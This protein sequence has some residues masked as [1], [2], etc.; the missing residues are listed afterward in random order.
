MKKIIMPR[1]KREIENTSLYADGFLLGIEKL[2]INTPYNFEEQELF[3][4]LEEIKDKEVF[5]ALT[6]NMHNDDLKYLEEIM[7]KLE[8]YDVKITYYDIAV[9]NIKERLKLKNDLVWN[10]EHL[11]NNYITSNFWFNHGAKYMITSSEITKREVNEIYEN[12]NC[13]IIVPVFG[14]IPMFASKRHLVKN[15]LDTFKIKDDSKIYYMKHNEDLYPIIDKEITTAYSS[16]VLSVIDQLHEIKADYYLLNSFLIE[17]QLFLNIVK[18]YKEVTLENKE[19][20]KEIIDSNLKTDSG[21][22]NKETV[23]KVK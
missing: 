9:V 4:I 16:N 20:F 15:Y 3:L 2:S 23:Y 21:F 17:E 14:Y 7:I 5:I 10:Q 19:K 12:S 22:F 11:T 8:K 13:K 1:S 6:K 18:M